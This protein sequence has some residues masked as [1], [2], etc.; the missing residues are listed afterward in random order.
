MIYKNEQTILTD[1]PSVEY[2]PSMSQ[3]YNIFMRSNFVVINRGGAFV[4]G[5]G[6]S[7]C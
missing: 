2:A 7:G 4:H 5:D 1:H 3:M 6:G